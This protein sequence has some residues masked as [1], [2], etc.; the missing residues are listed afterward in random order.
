MRRLTFLGFALLLATA[1]CGVVVAGSGNL[2]TEMREVS[3]FDRVALEGC[4]DLTII[5]GDTESLV[6]K[7]E[8][9]IMPKI[10]S[11]VKDGTLILGLDKDPFETF[12]L[13]E[14]IE[15][16]LTA[17]R[18]SG[19]S[20]AGS[21]SISSAEIRTD[22]MD[23]SIAGSGDVTIDYLDGE[24]LSVAI[25]GSG[26]CEVSGNVSRQ[27]VSI[28]GSGDYTSRDLKSEVGA[29]SISGSGDAVVWTTESLNVDINGSG[30]VSYRG[31]PSVAKAVNGSGSVAS[32]GKSGI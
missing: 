23:I 15:Y 17:R 22:D 19:L 27:V 5:Q 26:D 18:I 2:V 24:S 31:S 16:T 10:K 4:G 25:A 21:G 28:A 7:A 8:D 6:I 3:G 20:L 11:V 1:G 29:V 32:L 9:N 30:D 12:R 14:S 13:T